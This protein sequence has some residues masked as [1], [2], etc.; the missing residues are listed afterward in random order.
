MYLKI[1]GNTLI[2]RNDFFTNTWPSSLFKNSPRLFKNSLRNYIH[3]MP[4]N[5]TIRINLLH[6]QT[7]VPKCK[8]FINCFV[9]VILFMVV[10]GGEGAMYSAMSST[11]Q[12]I[13]MSTNLGFE[14]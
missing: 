2:I 7:Q 9:F 10:G 3:P 13:N 14:N 5:H 8:D 6:V 12:Q 1:A 11:E 4:S